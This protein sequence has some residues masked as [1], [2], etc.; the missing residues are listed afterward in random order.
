M[1]KTIT[2]NE[3]ALKQIIAESVKNAFGRSLKEVS[4]KTLVH[5]F[6]RSDNLKSVLEKVNKEFEELGD[7]LAS[8]AGTTPYYKTTSN[9]EFGEICNDFNALWDRF[10]KLYRRKQSQFSN[11]EDEYIKRDYPEI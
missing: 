8:L 9:R 7:S 4:D 10:K 2:L 5:A 1:K 6:E 11:F 3:N